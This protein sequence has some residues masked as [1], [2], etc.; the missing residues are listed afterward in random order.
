MRGKAPSFPFYPDVWLSATDISLMTPAEE[1]AFIRLLCIAWLEPDCG[2][3]DDDK[4][5]AKLSRLNRSWNRVSGRK[6]LSKFR[7][8][9]GRLYNDRLLEEWRKRLEWKEKSSQG[10]RKS[11]QAKRKGGTKG[12]SRVVD[13]C[14]Q[15]NSN[16][17]F[18]SSISKEPPPTPSLKS[19][20][21]NEQKNP[22]ALPNSSSPETYFKREFDRLCERYP[23]H[24]D[25]DHAMCTW[26]SLIDSAKLTGELLPEVAAGLDRWLA[27]AQWADDDGKY[28]PKLSN[29]LSGSKGRRWLEHPK[30]KPEE[31]EEPD[32]RPEWEDENGNLRPEFADTRGFTPEEIAEAERQVMGKVS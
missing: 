16:I 18:S 1:G 3:P 8:E 15:P 4:I 25:L 10:G 5:L 11:A 22:P 9:N 30:P 17:S 19:K 7:S 31:T 27:S 20:G 24:V 23:G 14:L 29:W 13:D 12:G 21:P 28:I 26:M 6:L 2:L 32:W